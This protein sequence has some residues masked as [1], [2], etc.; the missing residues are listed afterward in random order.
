MFCAFVCMY[1]VYIDIHMK[2]HGR[3][4]MLYMCMHVDT[5]SLMK[6]VHI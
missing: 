2:Q 3:L 1:S 4:L 5:L 6:N